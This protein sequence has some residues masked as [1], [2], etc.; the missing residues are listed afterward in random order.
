M[1]QADGEVVWS[2]HPDADVKPA[3]CSRIPLVTEATKPG[4]RGEHEG[5][6]K[7]IAQGMPECFG[8]PVVTNSYAFLFACEAAGASRTRHSL[9]PLL[10]G[11]C[12]RTTRAKRAAR[13]RRCVS[14]KAVLPLSSWPG[15][16]RP[17][18]PLY[19]AVPGKTRM[20]ATSAGMTHNR[21]SPRRMGPRFRGDDDE[22]RCRQP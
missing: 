6:R 12:C 3:R 7:T 8:E 17:S 15:L 2:W 21:V 19:P 13:M 4:L 22:R 16:T 14:C 18:T 5:N 11:H 9:R 10:E 20:P 1:T